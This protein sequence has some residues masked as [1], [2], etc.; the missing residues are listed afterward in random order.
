MKTRRL[1]WFSVLVVAVL[2]TTLGWAEQPRYG[3]SQVGSWQGAWC[4]ATARLRSLISVYRPYAGGREW[5]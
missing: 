3:W 4:G 5:R 2:W 1:V